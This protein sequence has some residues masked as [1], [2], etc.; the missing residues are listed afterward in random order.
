MT[1]EYTA[2][3]SSVQGLDKS[4]HML[5]WSSDGRY[6]FGATPSNRFRIWETGTWCETFSTA[7]HYKATSVLYSLFSNPFQKHRTE[8][9]RAPQDLDRVQLARPLRPHV[10]GRELELLDVRS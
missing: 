6:L 4:F 3:Q 10:L 9:P 1:G 2:L 5:R 7:S 8:P